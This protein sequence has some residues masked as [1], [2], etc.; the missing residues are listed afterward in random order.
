AFATFLGAGVAADAF[1]VAL[2]LPNMF[3]R[4]SAEGAMTNAFLPN[5]AAIRETYGRAAALKLAAEAQIFLILG[6]SVLVI[7]AEIFMA[8]LIL[9]LAPG[10]AN[11][12][13]RLAAAIDLARITMPY[14]PLISIVA[15]WAAIANAHD[16]FKAGAAA[17]IIANI[18]FIA[19]AVM[20]PF[21]ASHLDALRAIPIAAALVVA[22]FAQLVF[23]YRALSRLHAVPALI[24]PRLSDAGCKMWRK[25]LPAA[26]GAGGMQLN[27]L[28][29]LIL[30]SLLPV[31]AIS[32]LYYADRVAQLPLG[33]IGIAL[34]TA[35]LPK[36]SAA[37]AAGQPADVRD[38]LS[39]AISFA[40]FF[41][42]PAVT[43][44]VL[45]GL[46]IINGLFVYGAFTVSDAKMAA[47]A[48][49]A[50]GCGLPGFVL[51]KILQ[52]AFYAT[53]QP[54]VVLKISL[55]TVAINVA[56]SLLLMPILGHVGLALATAVSGTVA[57]AI[58]LYLLAR[59]HRLSAS[60]LPVCGKII[61]AS[62]IMGAA[63]MLL[64]FG[65][66][67]FVTVPAAVGLAVIVG[68]GGAVYA[69][70]AYVVGAVPAGLLR[71]SHNRN[72]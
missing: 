29:D 4:L 5:Y 54:A 71:Q 47:M 7:I 6:L 30:A 26:A 46:P 19:G 56:G 60:F 9:L 67:R 24:W 50:Y 8:D 17:P 16:H 3:R 38:N 51:V 33:V 40:G 44:L 61:L 27:L 43:G 64:Q 36:L 12:P 21:V 11:S 63:I 42:I 28:I 72:T 31:G 1:L 20:I 49:A 48:L 41:V 69:V 23:L 58:M 52:T 13:D 53:G 62:A 59:Q 68:G 2:K 18:C 70:T 22:G 37:E 55:I 34:G 65:V 25:F 35:L 45:C 66:D 14:L 10:F 32:W 39:E 15:L 57:A